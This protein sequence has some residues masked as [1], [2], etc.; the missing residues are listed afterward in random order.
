[1]SYFRKAEHSP[2]SAFYLPRALKDNK[3]QENIM[4][5]EKRIPFA[6]TKTREQL[7]YEYKEIKENPYYVMFRIPGFL[8]ALALA[9]NYYPAINDSKYT[10]WIIYVVYLAI[11]IMMHLSRVEKKINI[12]YEIEKNREI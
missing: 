2:C 10:T 1:M 8:I 12:L 4:D 3:I 9:G 5:I 7:L 6:A 11:E